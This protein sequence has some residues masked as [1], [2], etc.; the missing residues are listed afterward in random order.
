MLDVLKRIE[1]HGGKDGLLFFICDVIGHGQIKIQDAKI[2]CT[3]APGKQY[4]SVEQIVSYCQAMGWIHMSD[5]LISASAE[6]VSLLYDREKL[7][8]ALVASSVKQLFQENIFES[9]MFYYDSVRYCY[10][11]KNELLPLSLSGVRN[12]LISQGFFVPQ[13]DATGLSRLYIAPI[14]DSL[15]AKQCAAKRKQMSLALLKERLENNEIVGEK[16]ELFTLEYEKK[17]IGPSLSEKIKRISEIDV[18]AGYD[19]VSYESPQSREPDRF[20]EV[21]AIS[22]SGFY[23]SKNELEIAKLKGA[24]YYL[25]LVELNKIDQADY[26]PLIIQNPS[27]NIME[28]N[29]W[30][31]ETQ[32]YFIKHI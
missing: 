3:H 22:K 6:L 14:Y 11:F 27:V 9:N 15:I 26:C 19:I 8:S 17:R 30:L 13:R 16:A 21:K 29:D 7:N 2:L 18:T 5:D 28:G 10:A 25:Y 12:I 24:S 1:Y 23:W 4:L 20:I 32:T 31:A